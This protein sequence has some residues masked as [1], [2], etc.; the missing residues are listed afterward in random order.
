MG[1]L[2]LYLRTVNDNRQLS[3]DEND[4]ENET[5]NSDDIST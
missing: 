2:M 5:S 3:T 1:F 4:N